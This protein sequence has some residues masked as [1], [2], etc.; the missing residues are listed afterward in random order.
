MEHEKLSYKFTQEKLKEFITEP[1]QSMCEFSMYGKLPTV[2]Y[3]E[4]YFKF[5]MVHLMSFVQH[6]FQ[7]LHQAGYVMFS[8][9]PPCLA[10]VPITS[11]KVEHRF[12]YFMCTYAFHKK[13]KCLQCKKHCK[14]CKESKSNK[15]P[16][17]GYAP[18]P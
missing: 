6:F 15:N 12:L 1:I 4:H 9:W 7:N 3:H 14:S 11:Q 5:P 17:Q 10:A 8:L 2:Y 16:L 13:N 18:Y